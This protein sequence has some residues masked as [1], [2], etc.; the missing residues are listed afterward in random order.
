MNKIRATIILSV[1]M[2]FGSASF[3]LMSCSEKNVD[4][5][6]ILTQGTGKIQDIDNVQGDGWQNF[7]QMRIIMYYPEEPGG[8]TKVLTEGYY[9]AYSPV[10]SYDG[11]SMLFTAKQ[12]QD[13]PWQIW[14]MNLSDSKIRKVISF[15]DNCTDPDYLPGGRL[16]FGKVTVKDT[17]R[18]ARNIFVCN[19]DGSDLR[20]LTFSPNP[21]SSLKVL[22]DGRILA[23]NRQ[24]FPVQGDQAFFALRPDGTKAD[25]FYKGADG[26]LLRSCGRETADNK[27][28]F[29]ESEK[30]FVEKG[31]LISINYNRPLNSRIDL[32]SGLKGSFRSAFP[33]ESGRMLVSY[34]PVNKG[35]YSLYEFDSENMVPD[36]PIYTDPDYDILEAV[37]VGEHKQPKKL[38]SEV[39]KGV[40]TGL[41]LCTDINFTNMMS[42]GTGFAFPHAGKIEVLGI[43]STMG[44]VNVEKDGS[45]YLK[46]IANTPFRIQ[47]VDDNGHVMRGPCDWIWLRPNERRGCI[48]CHENREMTPDNRMALSV[49]KPPVN[50]PQHIS[51]I[52]EKEIE[53]E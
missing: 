36:N 21:F 2:A 18:T 8:K 33:L 44:V 47:T 14:E 35:R 25:I 28:I 12:N 53:L 20:Q 46:V 42:S 5:A 22:Q 10:V 51:K 31:N 45:F 7:Q 40:K 39:D 37:V 6:I 24:M 16:I 48:G 49:K 38:P 13:D 50:I 19:L 26:S 15:P 43:D 17:V 9:S 30:N 4:G 23:V 27:L 52:R 3:L 34:R 32:S 11:N 29:I 41:L 1:V